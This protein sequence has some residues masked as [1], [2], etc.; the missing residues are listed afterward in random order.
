MEH[1]VGY[2]WNA[3]STT[4]NRVHVI[5][6]RVKNVSQYLRHLEN[7]LCWHCT[8]R[9]RHSDIGKAFLSSSV[10]LEK[11][12]DSQGPVNTGKLDSYIKLAWLQR[13]HE[14][15]E[16]RLIRPCH[17]MM[18]GSSLRRVKMDDYNTKVR[19]YNQLDKASHIERGP[20]PPLLL[21]V[22]RLANA[23]EWRQIPSW[24]YPGDRIKWPAKVLVHKH[25][26]P[27]LHL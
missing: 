3:H 25:G 5:T 19:P 6:V 1:L 18:A 8:E 4:I 10:H 2:Y 27:T 22:S 20:L 17:Q 12:C 13:C 23:A 16:V 7:Q 24:G 26:R 21:T 14:V 9:C 15:G 11:H